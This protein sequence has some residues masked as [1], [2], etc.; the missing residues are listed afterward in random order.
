MIILLFTLFTVKHVEFVS[1][2]QNNLDTNVIDVPKNGVVFFL[3]KQKI[4]QDI[5]LQNP[6]I[7]IINIETVF[8]NKLVVHFAQREE[9]FAVKDSRQDTFY[10]LDEDFVVI[11]VMNCATYQSLQTN[12]ILIEQSFDFSDK[13]IKM[14]DSLTCFDKSS[15][16]CNVTKSL[17]INNRDIAEQKALIKKIMIE[18][19][20][21]QGVIYG[22]QQ[23]VNL[24]TFD[25]FLIKIYAPNTNLNQKVQSML[26]SLSSCIPDY[27]N[28]H[29]L[30][31]L[32]DKQGEIFC[33]LSLK[34]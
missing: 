4:Q 10:I 24:W 12:A 30:E 20:S 31:V 21:V 3:D 18:D 15:L 23:V 14:G 13:N 16:F 28:T 22:D 7:K 32:Q 8:P 26:A 29:Y 34:S 1:H 2:N 19:D 33:K 25:D 5:Q 11:N 27:L 17:L 6:L 9:V